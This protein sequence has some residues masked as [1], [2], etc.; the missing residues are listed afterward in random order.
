[1]NSISS[2]QHSK[3]HF[4]FFLQ[5]I[6]VSGSIVTNITLMQQLAACGHRVSLLLAKRGETHLEKN[7]YDDDAIEVILL[8]KNSLYDY[9]RILLGV[10][11]QKRK[12]SL[13]MLLS[14]LGRLQLNSVATNIA[15][16]TKKHKVDFLIG[17]RNATH[18]E[19]IFSTV[20]TKTPPKII[21]QHHN[22]KT[23]GILPRRPYL[24]KFLLKLN[25]QLY[26][27]FENNISLIV[28]PGKGL[29]EDARNVIKVQKMPYKTIYN[30][31]DFSKI[32]VLMHHDS[33]HAW[34]SDK[35]IPVLLFVGRISLQKDIPT[36]LKAFARVRAQRQ[37]RMI[38]AGPAV[39]LKAT[40]A[41]YNLCKSPL[42][43]QD[44]DIIG[45]VENSYSLMARADVFV[46]SSIFE[47]LPTVLIEALAC[48][49]PIVST[50]CRY[51]P[52]EIIE[53][54]RYGKLVPVSD[55]KKMA[56]AIIDTLDNPLPRNVLIER[57]HFF[58]T[59]RAVKS[60]EAA[61]RTLL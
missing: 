32:E 41:V 11:Q 15:A 20:L 47:G 56:D 42:L 29:I 44:V 43:N 19:V 55:D 38:I 23:F 26:R 61:A 10:L 8:K 51:G 60:Y 58:S 48:G 30:S 22:N 16:Y 52:D 46:L 37:V 50:D 39:E 53:G 33:N 2:E 57:A 17:H 4:A 28:T 14:A 12:H 21:L 7:L 36:L 13:L 5:E 27:F 24:A 40:K 34:L 49:C 59:E 18:V 1:M 54:G 31:L 9:W 35:T 6:I 45:V 25:S 3:Y